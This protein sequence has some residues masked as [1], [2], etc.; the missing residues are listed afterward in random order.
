[1]AK[2]WLKRKIIGKMTRRITKEE[3][4]KLNEILPN[5]LCMRCIH[6]KRFALSEYTDRVQIAC[7][8]QPSPYSNSGYKTIKA[9]DYACGLY[10]E[11]Q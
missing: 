8:M 5:K 7:E 6:R 9:H 2:K 4:K 11:R 10:K 1:M 3:R